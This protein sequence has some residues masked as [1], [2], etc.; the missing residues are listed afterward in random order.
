MSHHRSFTPPT[1]LSSAFWNVPQ[2]ATPLS[3][4]H[5]HVWR[6]ILDLPLNRLQVYQD[7]V[8]QDERERAQRLILP[9]HQRRFTAA[10]GLLRH[11]LGRYLGTPPRDIRFG[12]GP[13]GKPFLR[14]PASPTLYFNVAHSHHRAVYAVSRDLEVGI[15]L[16]GERDRADY[17]RLAER[18][19]SPEEFT[20][21]Q[22]L[23]QDEHKAAFF[24]CWTRKEAW[25]K[26]EGKGLVFPLKHL[27]VSFAPGE[28]PRLLNVRGQVSADNQ[29]SLVNLPMEQGFWGALAIKGQPDLVRGWD[30]D[31]L[32]S[33]SAFRLI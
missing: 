12:V 2:Q 9:T 19:C 24:S 30:Y 32:M 5:V 18:I 33:P 8:S 21:F 13:H 23:P 26:A 1:P 28:P 22:Q 11:I 3:H 17:R 31:P 4:G 25:V 7:A 20:A 16:E 29:W 27:T 14:Y 10:R 6:G 15:D